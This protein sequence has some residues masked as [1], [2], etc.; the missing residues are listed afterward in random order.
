MRGG[1]RLLLLAVFIAVARCQQKPQV[2]V[3]PNPKEI[4]CGDLV[5]LRC[6]NTPSGSTVKWYFNG[7]LNT[8]ISEPF[9]IAVAHP[10][11][12]GDYECEVNQEKSDPFTITVLE[13][14][15][16]AALT[17]KTGHPV[18]QQGASVILNLHNDDG[19]VGWNCW[20]YRGDKIKRIKLK[21]ATEMSFD[22]Q[23]NKLNVAETIF[24]CSNT[25]TRSNQVTVRTTGKQVSLE[26]YPL[27]AVV[28]ESLTLRC[29]V[30]GTDKIS[31]SVFYKG[32]QR[33]SE[34]SNVN[35]KIPAV[36]E[37]ERGSY[38]CDATFTYD[39]H[40]SSTPYHVVSDVQD[41]PVQVPPAKAVLSEDMSCS[42]PRCTGYP[43]YH[44]Y[45]KNGG[46]W[47]LFSD[48]G[49]PK[50]SGTFACRAVWKK[51]RSSM[52]NA[53]TYEHQ[54]S[55][56]L[57][58]VICLLVILLVVA[59]LIYKKYRRRNAA[60][61]VYED[62]ALRARDKGDPEYD[63][64]NPEAQDK[65]KNEGEYEPLKKEE[66][67]EG[68]YHTL[69]A[70]G[71]AGGQGGYEALKKQGV[72]EGVY[73]TLGA[74]GAAGGEGGYEALKKGE[75]K[76]GVYHTLG[77][78]GAAGGEGGYEALKKGEIKDGVYHTLGAE[79]A[80]G[81][82]GGYEAVGKDKKDYE[83]VDEKKEAKAE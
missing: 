8:T 19:L 65:R 76:D 21:N 44:W 3:S 2:S 16:T 30:W 22:F 7:K 43:H 50:E 79:G 77:A 45:K 55:Y 72:K 32:N 52:S 29:L 24:W 9:K 64:I 17:I 81:G 20:V 59:V 10:E 35:Y 13:Y 14:M 40:T 82:E 36:T 49:S 57:L 6:E 5:Y 25:D 33:L 39:G 69:G 62:V 46:S 47:V 61:A 78:E 37:A 1:K 66:M 4:F 83:V 34:A 23:P 51:M 11:H 73:H 18:M 71:A 12:T 63:T 56:T 58:I 80:A 70:E 68:E 15:P 53:M 38:K 27:P 31:N 42:C 28:G 74:E 67:K 60:G 26:M 41:L 48:S 75:I 54:T